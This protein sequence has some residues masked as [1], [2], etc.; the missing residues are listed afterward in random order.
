MGLN[1]IDG[2]IA[3][4]H[5]EVSRLGACSTRSATSSPTRPSTCPLALALV[6]G[7]GLLAGLMAVAFALT[8]LA[9]I[10]REP[11]AASAATTDPSAR[12]TAPPTRRL[13]VASVVPASLGVRA[14]DRRRLVLAGLTVVNR[15]RAPAEAVPSMADAPPRV[16]L[17]LREPRAIWTLLVGASLA[18][19]VMVRRGAGTRPSSP[20]ACAPGGGSSARS[21]SPRRRTD[22]D[23]ILFAGVSLF[24]LREYLP[25]SRRAPRTGAIASRSSPCRRS[26]SSSSTAGTASSPSSSRSS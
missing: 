12:R 14:G 11:S 2:M 7:F 4:E 3:R 26:T 17:A 8:E 20:P 21:P 25:S 5:G 13:A 15:L 19:A 16:P 18:V 6:P 24:A 1:A 9:G 10:P 22:G 23:A